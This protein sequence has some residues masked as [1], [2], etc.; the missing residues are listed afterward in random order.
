MQFGQRVHCVCCLSPSGFQVKADKKGRPYGVCDSCGT[1]MF[2]RGQA[3]L[4]G[5][6]FLWG[7]LVRAIHAQDRPAAEA[8][9]EDG[10]KR[11]EKEHER[12]LAGG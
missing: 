6:S 7:P 1:R 9:I 3:S 11:A 4:R 8:M 10:A 2:F 5:V 12:A